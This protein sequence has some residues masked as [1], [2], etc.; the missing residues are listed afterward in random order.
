MPNSGNYRNDSCDIGK[1]MAKKV[2]AARQVD[3]IGTFFRRPK[4]RFSYT[5]LPQVS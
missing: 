5:A 3:C 2:P 4:S 1:A